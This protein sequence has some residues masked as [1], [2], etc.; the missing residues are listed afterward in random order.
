MGGNK[1]ITNEEKAI[2]FIRLAHASAIETKKCKE[3]YKKNI[4]ELYSLS[5]EN[6]K[7]LQLNLNKA[8]DIEYNKKHNEIMDIFE[9]F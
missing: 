7:Y 4:K 5:D 2:K 6:N 9:E 1:Q 3:G 8:A